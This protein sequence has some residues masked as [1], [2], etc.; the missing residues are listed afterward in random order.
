MKEKDDILIELLI[1]LLFVKIFVH[2]NLTVS[3]KQMTEIPESSNNTSKELT[4]KVLK[5]IVVGEMGTGKTSWIRQYVQGFFSEFYKTTIGVDF[6]NKIIKW[7]D[8][9]EINLQLWDIAGQERYGNMTHVYFQEAVGALV[10]FDVTRSNSL[11][12]VK[13]WKSD[14]DTKVFTSQGTPIP[15]LLLGN[16]ID[17]VPDGKWAQKDEMEQYVKDHSFINFFETSARDA[18]NIEKAANYLVKYIMDNNIE[19]Q[20]VSKGN[21]VQ[22]DHPT[23]QQNKKGCCH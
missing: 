23:G 22:L 6:A 11:D 20:S 10:M 7:E 3:P 9:I 16:K 14:I 8:G 21:N 15:C 4:T 18:T 17:L 19:A 2:R 12:M 1:K 13:D 5:V